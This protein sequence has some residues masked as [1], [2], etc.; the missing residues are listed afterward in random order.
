MNISNNS[1]FDS[2]S[3][4]ITFTYGMASTIL[5]APYM[6]KYAFGLCC[7]INN[8]KP[9]ITIN[10]YMYIKL[11]HNVVRNRGP[12]QIRNAGILYTDRFSSSI[13]RTGF[14]FVP[15]SDTQK[16]IVFI[17]YHHLFL[18]IITDEIKSIINPSSVYKY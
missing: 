16:V 6:E 10:I 2:V 13:N 5:D 1:L 17:F 8:N 11:L 14:K 18:K 4:Q 7:L 12:G 15:K 9:G 3:P